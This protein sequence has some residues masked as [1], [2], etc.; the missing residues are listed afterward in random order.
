MT[1]SNLTTR[2]NVKAI[3]IIS[4][5]MLFFAIYNHWISYQERRAT[6]AQNMEMLTAYLA[7]AIPAELLLVTG[8]QANGGDRP[9]EKQLLVMN[10]KLQSIIRNIFLSTANTVKFGVY[11]RQFQR[12]VA[13]GPEMDKSLLWNVP[14][15]AF[16]DMFMTDRA[17]LGEQRRSVLWYGSHISY[18]VRP[19]E[20]QGEIIG[21]FFACT[22][23]D[24]IKDDVF[25]TIQKNVF[26]SVAALVIAIMLFQDIFIRLKRE[27]TLFAEATVEGRGREFESK[28]PELNPI[29]Q[30]L[31]EQTEQ[32][33]RLD[34]LNIIGEMAASI[35]HEVRNPMTT[36]RGFLQHLG[37]KP[38][39]TDY[40][41]QFELMIEELDRA[42]SIITDFLSLAKNKAMNFK[43]NDLNL[44]I[45]DVIP[46]L[47]ADAL[48][49]NCQIILN[50]QAVP[51]ICLDENSLRQLILNIV[52]N[53][54]EAMPQGGK[55]EIS[56][57]S[58]GSRVLLTF[59]DQGSGIANEILDKLGTPFFT[60][61]DN[62]I[63]LGLAVCHRIVQRH[64]AKIAVESQPGRGSKF[65]ITFTQGIKNA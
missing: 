20:Y 23:L 21:Y 7:S 38:A 24:K 65:I 61:K 55:V 41:S 26:G 40:G 60:T 56:T 17:R 54:I 43:D 6:A 52:R 49:F 2:L 53:G 27:L 31:S 18:Y 59:A 13:I 22:N 1:L 32:M 44:I 4:A 12:I 57:V 8:E 15:G 39:F 5:V 25:L 29:L 14:P 50:L 3:C 47:E 33:A 35:G 46:M 48:R 45:R 36:V 64:G 51:A 58:Q 9:T 16:D 63:G 10:N 62:G 42:N 11:S 28:I 30:H 19:I 34:R 37:K